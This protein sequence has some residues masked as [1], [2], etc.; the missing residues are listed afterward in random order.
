MRLQ[1]ML[2]RRLLLYFAFPLEWVGCGRQSNGIHVGCP[3]TFVF[4]HFGVCKGPSLPF[5]MYMACLREFR[6]RQIV[7]SSSFACIIQFSLS[8]SLFRFLLLFSSLFLSLF[9]S[10]RFRFKI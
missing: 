1:V 4:P 6:V 9:V 2:P 10:G 5:T 8:L 7:S 3:A